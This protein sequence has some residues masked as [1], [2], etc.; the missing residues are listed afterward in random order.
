MRGPRLYNA[1]ADALSRSENKSPTEPLPT[2]MGVP[3]DKP[4]AAKA[5]EFK[6]SLWIFTY[7]G[8]E[9]LSGCLSLV[10]MHNPE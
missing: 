7:I 5:L 3:P 6:K 9:I 8:N 1:M 2:A 10:Q 4:A